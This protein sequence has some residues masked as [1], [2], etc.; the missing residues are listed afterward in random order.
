M[1]TSTLHTSIGVCTHFER[2]EYGW[3]VEKLL[4]KITQAGIGVIRDEIK[5]DQVEREKGTYVIPDVAQEWLNH[6][7]QA[8]VKVLL[9]LCYGNPLYENPL[10]PNG[11]AAYARY[12]AQELGDRN[13]LQGYEIWNEPTNFHFYPTYGGKWSGEEPSLWREKFSELVL[14]ASTAIRE[15]DPHTP[16]LVNPGDPQAAHMLRHHSAAFE[17][18]NGISTHPYSVRFPPETVPF[19]GGRISSEDGVQVANDRHDVRSLY[20]TLKEHAQNGLGREL[21]VYA[22]EFGFPSY[23]SSKRGG[24]FD[25]YNTTT[26]AAYSVRAILLAL[27][28]NVAG[29]FLYDF[30][31]DG[32][33]VFDA[34][35]NFGLVNHESETWTEK[36]LYHAVS[37]LCSWLPHDAEPV[38]THPFS[39][40]YGKET[41]AVRYFWQEKPAEPF[42]EIH[43]PQHLVFRTGNQFLSFLWL[44]GRSPGESAPRH[45]SLFWTKAG[46]RPAELEILD[47]ISGESRKVVARP[48]TKSGMDSEGLF[49]S[50]LP[51]TENVIA[52]R[53]PIPS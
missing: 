48:P 25:G 52:I 5:W 36:P 39:L 26:Q 13:L 51:L 33:D 34:E 10:D 35:S 1:S 20:S 19:G 53:W 43:E 32:S 7:E 6:C 50:D 49:L 22:T 42:L 29:S 3:K 23:D 31:N 38:S 9:L 40:S 8:G 45:V 2:R 17:H 11:F 4:P 16:I 47:L 15:V 14:K 46:C 27:H 41:P 37:R 44:G 24:W 18:I 28:S 21:D 30:M 12:L